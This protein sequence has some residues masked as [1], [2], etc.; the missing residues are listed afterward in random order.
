[1]S[2]PTRIR[3]SAKA[4]VLHEG[5]VLLTRNLWN[6]RECH[7]LPGGGQEIGELLPDAVRREVREETGL[8]VQVG[9]LLWVLEGWWDDPSGLASENF[10]RVEVVFLCTVDGSAELVGGTEQDIDQIGLD[11]VPLEKITSLETL[12]PR[13]RD[14]M[15]PLVSGDIPRAAYLER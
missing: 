13:Y 14:H 5:S 2:V 7:F 1:M 15:I 4:V 6:G 9:P 10:H 8:T 11:W 3:T 12:S